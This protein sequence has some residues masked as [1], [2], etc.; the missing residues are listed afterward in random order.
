MMYSLSLQKKGNCARKTINSVIKP[1]QTERF[2]ETNDKADALPTLRTHW[3][4]MVPVVGQSSKVSACKSM[5]SHFAR[6][7]SSQKKSLI[8][9]GVTSS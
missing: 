6:N 7:S 8:S 2:K 3:T 1:T 5:S 4:N 9:S